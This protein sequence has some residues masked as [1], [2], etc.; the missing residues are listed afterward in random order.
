MKNNKKLIERYKR[1]HYLTVGQLKKDLEG[2]PDDALVVSQRVEDRYYDGVD[3]SGMTGTLADGT[4]GILPPGSKATG[5]SVITKPDPMWKNEIIQYSPVWCV[6]K[7]KDDTEC[8]YLDLH[9]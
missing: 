9:Y 1:G 8:L 2:Y 3:I 4:T 5:W 7:Y 6:V